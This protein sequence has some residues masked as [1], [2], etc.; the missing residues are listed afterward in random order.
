MKR[1]GIRSIGE[2]IG[3]CIRGSHMGQGLLEARV[4]AM[5]D[6]MAVGGLALRD[7]TSSR[8]FKDGVLTCKMRSSV[9]RS[10]LQ[11]QRD[12]IR[13]QLNALLGEEV[14]K[15]IKLT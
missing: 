13:L 8:R 10:H 1:T 11:F 5:W 4:C 3:D 15:Q 12:A 6:T 9:V 14:V 7:Q 2:V